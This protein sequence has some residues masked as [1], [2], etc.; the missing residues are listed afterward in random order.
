VVRENIPFHT[1]FT[2]DFVAFQIFSGHLAIVSSALLARL[3]TVSIL[4]DTQLFIF[5]GR[6]KSQIALA[7]LIATQVAKTVANG[8]LKIQRAVSIAAGIQ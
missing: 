8:A 7:H 2:A 5:S 6:F 1:H 4:L 3:D